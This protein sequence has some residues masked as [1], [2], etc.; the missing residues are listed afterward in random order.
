MG[1]RTR[2]PSAPPA[3]TPGASVGPVRPPLPPRTWQPTGTTLITG[4]TGGLGTHVARW[5]ARHG[6]PHLHLISRSG[7]DAP[8]AAQL[9]Q[10]LTGLGAA[11]TITACDASDRAALQ[12][13]LDTI[14]A[15]HPSPPSSTPPERRTPSS[16]P[17]LGRSDYSMCSGPRPWP[18]PICM[19]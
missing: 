7:P 8:G 16:S 13:L 3:A 4:G 18:P 15:E 2:P 12:H 11:V 1:R 19:S 14:P 17:T 6:A 9:A 5:L 10:E